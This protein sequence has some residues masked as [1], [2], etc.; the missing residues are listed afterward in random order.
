MAINILFA[1]CSQPA[2]EYYCHYSCAIVLIK[3]N[4]PIDTLCNVSRIPCEKDDNPNFVSD[5]FWLSKEYLVNRFDSIAN[6][7][8]F[9]NTGY[10][11]SNSELYLPDSIG[12]CF[13]KYLNVVG[14]EYIDKYL[15][16]ITLKEYR[17]I[18]KSDC[19]SVAIRFKGEYIEEFEC[20]TQISIF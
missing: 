8:E 14:P 10:D 7:Y 6:I 5:T 18:K 17:A 11:H 1:A 16:S 3:D 13:R 19:D 9:D 4:T 20:T 12:C 2:Y 15:A